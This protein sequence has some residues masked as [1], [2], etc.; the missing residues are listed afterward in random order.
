[1][2]RYQTRGVLAGA[3]KGKRA[4]LNATLTHLVD[5]QDASGG[6]DALC[7]RVAHGNVADAHASPELLYVEPTCSRCATIWL[8]LHPFAHFSKAH[9]LALADALTQYVDNAADDCPG[10]SELQ[11]QLT[12]KLNKHIDAA[13]EMLAQLEALQVT[14]A[15]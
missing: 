15:K 9:V 8:E 10:E 5:T 14:W 7:R 3:Y 4:A 12:R 11:Q 6:F 1:M 13:R 2:T